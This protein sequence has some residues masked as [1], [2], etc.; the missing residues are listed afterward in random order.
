[1]LQP[2]SSVNKITDKVKYNTMTFTLLKEHCL[3]RPPGTTCSYLGIE[4][5]LSSL[6]SR[7]D[8]WFKSTISFLS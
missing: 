8:F 6:L 3:L 2:F 4:F 7:E 5:L 1:M